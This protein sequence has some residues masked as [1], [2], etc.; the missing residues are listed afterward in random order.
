MPK[1]L[2][3]TTTD[4]RNKRTCKCLARPLPDLRAAPR[5]AM[6]S[7]RANALPPTPNI[8][9]KLPIEVRTDVC[10]IGWQTEHLVVRR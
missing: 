8:V 10:Q 7:E 3:H 2:S 4:A 1:T 9:H 5:H 6:E